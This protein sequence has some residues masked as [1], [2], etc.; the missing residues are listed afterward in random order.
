MEKQLITQLVLETPA[1]CITRSQAQQFLSLGDRL[2]WHTEIIG[3]A[4][5]LKESVRL[6]DWLLV[7]AHEDATELPHRTLKRIQ[8]I[9]TQGLR[10]QGFVVVHEAPMQL[11]APKPET[12][13]KPAFEWEGGGK[14]FS[15]IAKVLG[16]LLLGGMLLPLGLLAGLVILDPILV[17]V[18]QDGYWIE[19]DRWQV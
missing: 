15:A 3:K 10:P 2:G 19:I 14:V 17:A 7:P 11:T 9:Y 6:Q 1:E 12:Q 8:T 16:A 18:T 13:E 4:P 5:M